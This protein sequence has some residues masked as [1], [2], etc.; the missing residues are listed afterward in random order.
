M[1]I[2]GVLWCI[3]LYLVIIFE[4]SA[5]IFLIIIDA[6]AD[7]THLDEHIAR[8]IAYG[9]QTGAKLTFDLLSKMLAKQKE[10]RQAALT[11]RQ[12]E[13]DLAQQQQL[14]Q[15]LADSRRPDMESSTQ[16]SH[17]VE[18]NNKQQPQLRPKIPQLNYP[19]LKALT[20]DAA[21]YEKTYKFRNYSALGKS[22]LK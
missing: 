22:K 19:N 13:M 3:Q 11:S 9:R 18:M 21:V 12:I 14:E 17:L 5:K 4:K 8:V 16:T 1:V 15:R 20:V 2:N 7:E 10:V 6:L